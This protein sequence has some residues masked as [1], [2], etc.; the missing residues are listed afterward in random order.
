MVAMNAQTYATD[1]AEVRA[2]GYVVYDSSW[3]L[4]PEL[5]RPDVTFVGVPL[6]SLCVEHFEKTRERLLMKNICYAGALVALL[7][8]DL[9]VIA[10]LLDE[11]F[12]GKVKLRESNQ[13]AL[14]LGYDYVREHLACPLPIHVEAMDATQESILIDGNTATALGCLFA[15]ATVAAWY[16]ITPSTSV[17]DNFASLCQQYRREALPEP[18]PDGKVE[19]RNNYL[20]LQAEDELAA[21]GMVL[22]ATWNGARAFTATSG[23]GISLMSELLGFAYYT[24]TPAVVVD[25]RGGVI[26][27]GRGAWRWRSGRGVELSS[28]YHSG[29]KPGGSSRARPMGAATPAVNELMASQ[30]T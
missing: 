23:P 19:Y 1:I 6:S 21:L 27:A 10:T 24:E 15:G 3:P 22:G 8:I 7:A 13:R 14:R 17:M 20:I 18:G 25:V 28:S 30:R 29:T 12:E 4:P 9:D 26:T 5:A 2:G 11:T 16:P